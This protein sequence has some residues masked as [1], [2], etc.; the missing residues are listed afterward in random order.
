MAY[1]YKITNKLN[2]KSY[3]G[4]TEKSNP[5]D[6]F[7]EHLQDSRKFPDRPLYRAINK[8]GKENF[9][10]KVLEKTS[11]PE[12]REV[13]LIKE[14][15]TYGNTGYNATKGGDGSVYLDHS[16]IL[17]DYKEVGNQEMVAEMNGCHV[18]SVYKILKSNNIEKV[19]SQEVNKK[20][21]GKPVHMLDKKSR[22]VL[23]TFETQ[24]EAARYLQ[25]NSFSNTQDTSA[26]AQKISLVIKGT[27]KSCSGFGWERV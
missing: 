21:Y 6:R 13:E 7:R 5:E 14:Y 9:S 4:K 15:N 16:K 24:K 26:L 20:Y 22:E 19:S 10:F 25:E 11:Y 23:K 12:E 27:R 2:G 8:Y 18:D 17:L 1:I 3:I